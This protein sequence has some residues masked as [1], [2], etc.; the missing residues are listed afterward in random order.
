MTA[1]KQMT[2]VE[3]GAIEAVMR[4][5]ALLEATGDASGALRELEHF[6]GKVR[7]RVLVPLENIVKREQ[8]ASDTFPWLVKSRPDRFKLP[9]N[10]CKS[11]R[12]MSQQLIGDMIMLDPPVC[13]T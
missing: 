13:F 7:E 6:M 8:E 9:I 12:R 10:S 5:V 3:R 1:D 2:C 4:M 11:R